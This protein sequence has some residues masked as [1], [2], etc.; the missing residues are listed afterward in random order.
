MFGIDQSI[1]LFIVLAGFSA[2]ALAYVFLFARIENE[3]KAGKRLDA[4]KK[5]RDRTARPSS[6]RVTGWPR[7]R[8][9]ASRC[10]IR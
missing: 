5:G 9:A 10:R 3:K 6:P 4:V 8:G 2:G 1:L 7:P